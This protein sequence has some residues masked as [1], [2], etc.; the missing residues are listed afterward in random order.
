[1]TGSTFIVAG[2]SLTLPLAGTPAPRF[3]D[4]RRGRVRGD[5]PW[6]I[7][8][9]E[10]RRGCVLVFDD[11]GKRGR[12]AGMKSQS[13]KTNPRPTT[14]HQRRRHRLFGESIFGHCPRLPPKH[15]GSS[16][17]PFYR[18]YPHCFGEGWHCPFP[19]QAFSFE[20]SQTTTQVPDPLTP[21]WTPM[22]VRPS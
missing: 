16:G 13:Q 22:Q 21:L 1:M 20:G 6:C 8:G 18:Q 15:P 5:R 7:F 12:L 17:V 9:V 2:T 14:T 4:W 10:A 3:A 11:P 19:A